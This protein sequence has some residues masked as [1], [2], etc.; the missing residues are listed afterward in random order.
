VRSGVVK[1]LRV[2]RVLM[3]PLLKDFSLRHKLL[4][5]AVVGQK[6]RYLASTY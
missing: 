2:L 4:P 6:K 1:L 3:R 5:I